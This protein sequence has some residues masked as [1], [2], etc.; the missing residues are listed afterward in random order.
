MATTS[1]LPSPDLKA[2]VLNSWKEIASYLGR[3]VRTVQRYEHE[4]Q[5]PVRRV[6][7]KSR[8]SVVALSQD[9]D[10]W[11]RHATIQK[12]DE[13]ES[14]AAKHVS[15]TA[16]S[17]ADLHK[18]RLRCAQLRDEHAKAVATLRQNLAEMVREIEA[19]SDLSRA[20]PLLLGN[21]ETPFAVPKAS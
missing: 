6:G 14:L 13:V 10:T 18:L 8:R 15:I 1:A 3:G 20:T 4:L 17:V 7:G 2:P 11:L 9:L 12:D 19:G 16:D 21:C 5:L